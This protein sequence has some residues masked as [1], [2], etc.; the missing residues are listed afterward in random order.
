MT[1]RRRKPTEKRKRGLTLTR[2]VTILER[3][4]DGLVAQCQ[5]DLDARLRAVEK[6]YSVGAGVKAVRKGKR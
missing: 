4:V 3:H 1:T 5:L 6:A 2:R